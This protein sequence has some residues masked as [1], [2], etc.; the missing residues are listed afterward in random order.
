MSEQDG[1]AE[2]W[3]LD[4]EQPTTE[5]VVARLV[6]MMIADEI[7]RQEK[8]L[9]RKFTREERERVRRNLKAEQVV[10]SQEKGAR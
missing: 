4:F 9:G 5:V 1:R 3:D 8:L 6:K 7:R 10:E 2:V